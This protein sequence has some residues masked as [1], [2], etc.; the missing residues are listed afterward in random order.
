MRELEDMKYALMLLVLS[1][2]TIAAAQKTI[3]YDSYCN[4]RF[5][6]CVSYPTGILIPEPVA[7]NGDG[8]RFWTKDQEVKMMVYGRNNALDQKLAELYAM[9]S[10]DKAEH[11]VSYKL[12]KKSWFVVS[13]IEND[14]VFYQKTILRNDQ[15]LTFRIEYPRNQRKLFDPI[16]AKIAASFK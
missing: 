3:T 9:E 13:G 7:G 4:A 8:R 6:Y 12:K 2:C 10:T 15:F 5:E 11:A 14:K 1:C 16:T